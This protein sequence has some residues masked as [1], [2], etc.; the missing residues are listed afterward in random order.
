[1]TCLGM[2]AGTERSVMGLS[3]RSRLGFVALM[4]GTIHASGPVLR[5]LHNRCRGHASGDI[6]RGSQHV[7]DTID[8]EQNGN[9]GEWY[10][11]DLQRR[12]Q[13]DEGR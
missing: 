6:H 1:M 2:S 8:S 4:V 11:R 13:G 3:C 10:A 12:R 9:A 5:S 7:R